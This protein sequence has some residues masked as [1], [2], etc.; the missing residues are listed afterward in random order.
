LKEVK[1]APPGAASYTGL[2]PQVKTTG[3]ADDIGFEGF[4][5]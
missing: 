2:S 3:Y 1:A 4:A 5:A